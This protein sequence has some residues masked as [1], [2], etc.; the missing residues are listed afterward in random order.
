MR[1]GDPDRSRSSRGPSRPHRG[2]AEVESLRGRH[3]VLR[4]APAR[5]KPSAELY[6]LRGLAREKIK[7]YQGA[8]EDYTM[9]I[10]LQPRRAEILGTQQPQ[11][12][13]AAIWARRGVLCLV[14]DAPRSALRDFQEAVR[15]D[16]TNADAYV[17]RG[18]ALAALGQH[19]E[20]VGD[21]AKA[22]EVGEPTTIRLYSA[23]RIY[24]QATYAAGA[25]ARKE[26]QQ[27]VSLFTR[28]QDQAMNLLREWLKRLPAS[29][30]ASSLH[31]LQEDP[32]MA[33]VLPTAT[34]A[35]PGRDAL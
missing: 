18:L 33:P 14:T 25:E 1:R 28:Y 13:S 19:R 35:G 16:S 2:P 11:P 26:G 23:A 6:E 9:A 10:G 29:D 32:A 31:D 4:C 27:A 20:A 15:L 8:I 5:G 3:P 12:K 30:R 22:L 17:G 24:A 34:F 7:D 21:A